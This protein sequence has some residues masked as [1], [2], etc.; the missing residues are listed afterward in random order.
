MSRDVPKSEGIARGLGRQIMRTKNPRTAATPPKIPSTLLSAE[1]VHSRPRIVIVVV[2]L[3]VECLLFGRRGAL[4]SAECANENRARASIR[5]RIAFLCR[6]EMWGMLRTTESCECRASMWSSAHCIRILTNP[7]LRRGRIPW[8]EGR[9]AKWEA[10]AQS[11]R[12][13]PTGAI[14]GGR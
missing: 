14:H 7:H 1:Q 11:W 10:W 5:G 3:R 12:I 2:E 13:W 6:A 8:E 9:T 4:H